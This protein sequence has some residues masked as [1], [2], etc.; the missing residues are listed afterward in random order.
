MMEELESSS[1]SGHRSGSGAPRN[2]GHAPKASRS[3]SASHES[4]QRARAAV[5]RRH[6]SLRWGL[7]LRLLSWRWRVLGAVCTQGPVAD[8]IITEVAEPPAALTLVE[9][10]AR[11][12]AP[13]SPVR[14][15]W[16]SP[17]SWILR[18]L[19]LLRPSRI[20]AQ[21]C[22]AQ[23][24]LLQK[25]WPQSVPCTGGDCGSVSSASPATA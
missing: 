13:R 9:A 22:G 19:Q 18:W 17:V 4:S 2:R 1:P 8:D 3:A 6:K 11:W 25:R 12:P 16:R 7:W 20:G 15:L 24:R 10:S 5:S 14:W 21:A 23:Q